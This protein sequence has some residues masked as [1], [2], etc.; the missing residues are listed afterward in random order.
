MLGYTAM[1]DVAF[2]DD[3]LSADEILVLDLCA[4]KLGCRQT[5]LLRYP[6]QDPTWQPL[7]GLGFETKSNVFS[8]K[9]SQ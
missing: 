2:W 4:S 8:L 1:G 7:L 3:T 6:E 5:V 9:Y